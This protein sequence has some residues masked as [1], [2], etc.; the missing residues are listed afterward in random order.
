[1]HTESKSSVLPVWNCA[2]ETTAAKSALYRLLQL[3]SRS[4]R[5]RAQI[6]YSLL[7]RT[8]AEQA[9]FDEKPRLPSGLV[10]KTY[11]VIF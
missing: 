9:E 2:P 11:T 3:V 10:S 7:E 1:M 6:V 5:H 4:L 8:L